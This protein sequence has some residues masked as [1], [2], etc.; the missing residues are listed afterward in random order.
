LLLVHRSDPACPLIPEPFSQ[1]TPGQFRALRGYISKHN[2]TTTDRILRTR[3]WG[4]ASI[5]LVEPNGH[6]HFS[7]TWNKYWLLKNISFKYYHFS[8]Y[9]WF[10]VSCLLFIKYS[11]GG[12]F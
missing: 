9:F 4:R 1:D 7:P 11:T 10:S 5:F 6:T 8:P 2:R 12:S 3:H